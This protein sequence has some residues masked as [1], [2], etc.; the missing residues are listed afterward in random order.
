MR[1]GRILISMIATVL[2]LLIYEFAFPTPKDASLLPPLIFW[3]SLSM[4][5]VALLVS[6]DLSQGKWFKGLDRV[7]EQYSHNLLI[8]PFLF[9]VF[10]L[11]IGIYKWTGHETEWLSKGFFIIRNFIILFLPFI[12]ARLYLKARANN[13]KN[14]SIFSILYLFSFVLSQSFIAFDL[15]MTLEYPWINTLFG[16]YFFVEAIFIAIAFSSLLISFLN[17][18][19]KKDLTGPIRDTSN[20]VMGFALLWVGLFFSQYLVIWYGNL[21]EEVS[22]ISKRLSIPYLKYFGVFVLLS[23]F[24]IPFLTYISRKSKVS[25]PVNLTVAF[26]VITGYFVEKL[27][28]IL[29]AVKL[30][31]LKLILTTIIIG[32][33]F[34][35]ITQNIIR[36]NIDLDQ[37]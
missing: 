21:P 30:N 12:F 27:L 6:I 9:L 13:S 34:L 25:F 8:F 24:I 37:N 4:G 19:M 23:L 32:I 14:R 3:S 26:F 17:K 20:M 29:P 18:K 7:F 15:V 5:I 22:F 33:P 11:N 28:L 2:I 35:I 16:A 31:P 36:S 1:Q 10:S